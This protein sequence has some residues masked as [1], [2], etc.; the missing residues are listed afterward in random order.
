MPASSRPIAGPLIAAVV[1]TVVVNLPGIAKPSMWY[2]EAASVSA[3]SRPLR[4]IWQ[5]IQSVD[6]VHG[7]YYMLLHGWVTV[8]G[9]SVFSMRT[10]SLIGLCIATAGLSV[11]ARRLDKGVI[12]WVAAVSVMAI[13]P[14]VS[15][16][17]TEIR[18][19]VFALAAMVWAFVVL[20]SLIGSYANDGARPSSIAARW[21]LYGLLVVASGYFAL[22]S[23]LCVPA[24]ILLVILQKPMRRQLLIGQVISLAVAFVILL[25]VLILG[26]Q[27]RQ[28][29]SWISYTPVRLLGSVGISLL[30]T[31]QSP[32]PLV[33]W[34]AVGLA[35]AIFYVVAVIGTVAGL[36]KS[37]AVTW[38]NLMWFV[39]P[40]LLLTGLTL[41]NWPIYQQRYLLP[42]TPAACLLFA[43][44]LAWLY[45]RHRVISW[46]GLVL[47]I[48][49]LVPGQVTLR[50]QDSR[51]GD[52][53]EALAT[54]AVGADQVVY[55]RTD[56]R[57]IG[58]A[59]PALVTG[60]A[61]VL[62]DKTPI[63]ASN[64]WGTNLEADAWTPSGTVVVYA[65]AM[66]QDGMAVKDMPDAFAARLASAN[67][68]FTGAFVD[69][70][71]FQGAVFNCPG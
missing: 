56:S 33:V 42:M 63:Q 60:A 45:S 37:P 62:L 21:A 41:M 30:F 44:G 16:E 59:Y 43:A 27:Q 52:D 12:F 39:F 23:L 68:V 22:L 54:L 18:A 2:D 24:Q 64:L 69:T 67:C 9:S 31:G 53:Y 10:L 36:R 32:L 46:V 7:L 26:W 8:C 20:Q 38:A 66:S 47:V 49:C 51:A 14:R 55:T 50:Q 5:M 35:A 48:A 17:G 57:G 4:D 40:T 1:A 61:D 15:R 25:P 13:L 65:R 3:V 29:I 70:L 34:A 11:Y 6:V 58:F 28:L 19:D 71:R